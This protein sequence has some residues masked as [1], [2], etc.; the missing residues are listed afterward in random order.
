M[1]LAELTV[2]GESKQ[3]EYR[4]WDELFR[5]K[6]WKLLMQDWQE[7]ATSLPMRAFENAKTWDELLAA[8]AALRKIEELLT[9]ETALNNAR[10]ADIYEAEQ[11]LEDD[12]VQL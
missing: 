10:D 5:C 9:W 8:R 6:G 12:S 3:T 7:E 1:S 11:A 2:L 4:Y